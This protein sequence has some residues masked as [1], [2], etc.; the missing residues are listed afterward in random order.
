M[1]STNIERIDVTFP[2]TYTPIKAIEQLIFEELC[3]ESVS[4]KGQSPEEIIIVLPLSVHVNHY[5]FGTGNYE[6]QFAVLSDMHIACGKKKVLYWFGIVPH[7]L[8][9][10]GT[11]G[12]WDT[13]NNPDETTPAIENSECAVEYINYQIAMGQPIRF[14]VCTGD[15]THSSEWSEY[16]RAKKILDDLID[17][18]PYPSNDRVF[19]I[20][21]FGNHDTWPYIG[22]P[23]GFGAPPGDY[24]E[25]PQDAVT[26]GE[27]LYDT[28][29]SQYDSL[30]N[31]FPVARWQESPL[32]RTPTDLTGEVWPSYYFNFAFNHQQYHFITTDFTTRDKAAPGWPGCVGYPDTDKDQPF[33]YTW[34]WLQ[35]QISNEKMIVLGHHAY[36]L[37]WHT[38][39]YRNFTPHQLHQIADAG[40]LNNKPIARSIGGH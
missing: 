17:Y 5:Y 20:P 29:V 26:I 37:S 15:I 10:F 8:P 13:D 6:F 12:Y 1:D 4:F 30:K 28:F 38:G 21:I 9:D 36:C 32:L 22:E 24:I 23:F 39:W 25:Q 14:V 40:L 35:T 7:W 16:Q 34:K 2:N 33:N 3:F 27:Y 11:N 19:Y 18:L 31:F